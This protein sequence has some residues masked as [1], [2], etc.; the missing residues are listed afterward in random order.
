[1]KD[2]DGTSEG[3]TLWVQ[4]WIYSA[5]PTSALAG[6]DM[7]VLKLYPTPPCALTPAVSHQQNLEAGV[8][9]GPLRLHQRAQGACSKC[10]GIFH[11]GKM[12]HRGQ[13]DNKAR[14]IRYSEEALN[15]KQIRRAAFKNKQSVNSV[16]TLKL[17]Q[18]WGNTCNN[19]RVL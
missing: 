15:G 13:D 4:L 3:S 9:T 18:E 11:R 5:L 7:Q 12:V 8:A 14:G 19:R 16:N 6:E 1:M 10:L 17:G 2:E